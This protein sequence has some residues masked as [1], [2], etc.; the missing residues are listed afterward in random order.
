MVE[1]RGSGFATGRGRGNRRRIG[2][3]GTTDDL[4]LLVCCAIDAQVCPEKGCGRTLGGT[5]PN[6]APGNSTAVAVKEARGYCLDNLDKVRHP[7][8]TAVQRCFV[9]SLRHS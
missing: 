3:L 1:G 8:A 7:P 2:A 6:V 9:N 5:Y 4:Y